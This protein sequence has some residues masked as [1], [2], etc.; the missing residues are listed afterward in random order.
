MP[1]RPTLK[2]IAQRAGLSHVAVSKALRDA[3]DISAETKERVKQ[4]ASDLGYTANITARNL[5][6]QRTSTIGMIVPEMGANMVYDIIF[7]EVS[8]AAAEREFSVILGSCLSSVALEEKH[9]RIMVGNQVGAIIAAPCTSDISHI[10]TICGSTPVIFIGGRI[11]PEEPYFLLCDYGYSGSEAV[12]YLAD[13]LGH[14]DIA[15]L[16]N[17]P[18]NPAVRQKREGY[19]K[20][21]ELRGLAP[22]IVSAGSV[23]NVIEAAE[24]AVEQLIHQ[25]KLPTALWC[26]SDHMAMGV[27][28][29]LEHHG[30]SVPG[31]VSVMGC[32]DLYADVTDSR[33]TT[34]HIPMAELGKA[35]AGMA[36]DLVEQR[37][38]PVPRQS[39][40]P[41]LVKR[42]TTGPA[43]RRP[44]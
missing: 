42:G 18:D 11:D 29:A 12:K 30:L 43:R 41:F 13:E 37:S 19:S 34:F 9:C 40:L 15:M 28:K 16:V 36:M 22:R 5:Y 44:Q 33:L 14:K 39:F 35:A 25:D 10:K 7:N 26:V 1:N 24:K 21:M 8:A 3:P 2:T 31:D 38:V 6:F 32:G 27:I 20:A 17:E 4:I 23:F